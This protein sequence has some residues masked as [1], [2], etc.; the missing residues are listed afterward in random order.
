MVIFWHIW[1]GTLHNA[2]SAMNAAIVKENICRKSRYQRPIRVVSQEE[3]I[4]SHTLLIGASA[5]T[6]QGDFLARYTDEV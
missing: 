6:E 2:V 1:P 4:I 3:Y 5:H